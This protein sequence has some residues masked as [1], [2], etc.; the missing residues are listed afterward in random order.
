M[1]QDVLACLILLV[2]VDVVHGGCENVVAMILCVCFQ[3]S[4][5]KTLAFNNNNN[6]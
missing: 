4:Y 5:Y 6:I 3:F 1:F 2:G